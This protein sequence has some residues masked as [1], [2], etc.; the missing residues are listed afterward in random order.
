MNLSMGTSDKLNAIINNLVSK[1][2]GVVWTC[3]VTN[4]RGLIVAG[5]TGDWSFNETVAAMVSLMSETAI[6]INTNLQFDEPQLASVTSGDTK[7]LIHE[8]MVRNR[9][10]RI[11]AILRGKLG[12][13]VYR[14]GRFRRKKD[15]TIEELVLEAA[16]D[17]IDI[18][19]GK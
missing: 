11:G 14:I 8:F 7:F 13:L 19:E 17:V 5:T 16:L 1:S 18:L 12:R 9:R 6:R 15:I 10:F 2:K 4:E 3:V